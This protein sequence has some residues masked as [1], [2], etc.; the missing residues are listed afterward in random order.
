L[1]TSQINGCAY[2]IDMHPGAAQNWEFEVTADE[3]WGL[4]AGPAAVPSTMI[5]SFLFGAS[6]G[7]DVSYR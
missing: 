7:I 1:R 4:L 2:C 3:T 5:K 6:G